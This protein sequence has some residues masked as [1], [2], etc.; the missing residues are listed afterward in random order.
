MLQK[1][2]RYVADGLERLSRVAL[3]Y[4]RSPKAKEAARFYET[5]CINR[6]WNVRLFPER[7]DAIEWLTA[8]EFFK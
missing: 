2:S 6:G 1:L 3:V 4:P 7:D 8:T 5:A